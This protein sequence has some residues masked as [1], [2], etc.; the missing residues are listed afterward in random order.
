MN[1]IYPR[2]KRTAIQQDVLPEFGCH[3]HLATRP[4]P[5]LRAIQDQ[6][7]GGLKQC[8]Q[9]GGE[10]YRVYTLRPFG[11]AGQLQRPTLKCTLVLNRAFFINTGMINKPVHLHLQTH[12]HRLGESAF[13]HM[14]G[15]AGTPMRRESRPVHQDQLAFVPERY[16]TVRA[17]AAKAA[18]G[19]S[20]LTKT[21]SPLLA[22]NR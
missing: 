10:P 9:N 20:F 21:G 19:I 16:G 4:P 7:Y 14:P 1:A 17:I 18:K 8:T 22:S 3:L 5:F 2:T 15:R 6:I 12:M 11:S 13:E